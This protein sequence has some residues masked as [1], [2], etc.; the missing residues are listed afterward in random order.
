MTALRILVVEDEA[1]IAELLSDVLEGMGHDV[2]AIAMTQVDAISAAERC[3]PDL[4]IVDVRLGKGSGLFAVDEILRSRYIPHVF[5]SADIS[6]VRAQRP[7]SV[8]MQKPYREAEL[9]SAIKRSLATPAA[10]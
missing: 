4:M 1:I 5:V 3:R 2:C 10:H 8:A 6:A 7:L 9:A